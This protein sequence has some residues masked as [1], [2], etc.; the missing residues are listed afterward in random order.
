LPIDKNEDLLYTSF[1]IYGPI[2]DCYA[3]RSSFLDD[4]FGFMTSFHAIETFYNNVS[5]YGPE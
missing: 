1:N 3:F 4:E 2:Q 5:G